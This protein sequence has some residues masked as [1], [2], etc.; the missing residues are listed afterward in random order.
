[1]KHIWQN[2]WKH[3][4]APVGW[5]PGYTEWIDRK[6]RENPLNYALQNMTAYQNNRP[7]PSE[8]KR[9]DNAADKLR[10]ERGQLNQFHNIN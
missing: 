8:Q 1:M 9:L 6:A 10:Y 4:S 2:R 5:I 3:F 7:T